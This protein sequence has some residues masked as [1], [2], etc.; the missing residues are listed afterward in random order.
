MFID[1]YEDEVS[2]AVTLTNSGAN[3]DCCCRWKRC[4][5]T[6]CNVSS[7]VQYDEYCSI[8]QLKSNV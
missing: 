6:D 3:D 1:F 2:T 4:C 5:H 8:V 7:D